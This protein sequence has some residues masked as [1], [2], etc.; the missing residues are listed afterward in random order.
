MNVSILSG[1]IV[2][3]L[4]LINLHS[5]LHLI[6][7]PNL[8]GH[9]LRT[10]QCICDPHVLLRT[11][12]SE[13]LEFRCGGWEYL[14]FHVF[15]YCYL[16]I[17]L[18]ENTGYFIAEYC[19]DDMFTLVLF[20]SSEIE[21]NLHVL[22]LISY[23]LQFNWLLLHLLLLWLGED[24]VRRL[25]LLREYV[26][27]QVIILNLSSLLRIQVWLWWSA[28]SKDILKEVAGALFGRNKYIISSSSSR[29]S[30]NGWCL[31]YTHEVVKKVPS[32]HTSFLLLFLVAILL[33]VVAIP[34][35]KQVVKV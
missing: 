20:F 17:Q 34:S 22:V 13:R 30:H 26:S 24:V 27:H 9:W 32:S 8:D 31:E 29:P 14:E 25:L 10:F 18:G 21:S 2:Q 16:Q 19:F 33:C 23:I 1:H 11:L 12:L 7:N 15:L 6:E 5:I 28:P 3:Y 35:I 4:S